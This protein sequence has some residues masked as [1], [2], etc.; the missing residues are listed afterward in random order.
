MQYVISGPDINKLAEYGN[1]MIAQ[2][3]KDPR[4][5]DLDLSLDLSKPEYRVVINRD[6]AH[7]LG[8]KVS[9]I[10]SALRT[11][12]GGEDDITKYKDGD[13]LYNV[14]VRVAEEY[15]DTKEAIAALM[16]PGKSNGEDTIVR[17]DSVATIEEGTGPS[18]I[19]RYNRQ[20]QVT[21]QA[22]LNIGYR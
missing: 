8:V 17:L 5:I 14:R 12:V 3:R 1:T 11:M 21:V 22:N 15:R 4:F 19:D 18:Q 6:K 2:L 7:S 9:S 16:V 13:E 10:A 20:R